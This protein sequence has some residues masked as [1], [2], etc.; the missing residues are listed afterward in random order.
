MSRVGEDEE[1]HAEKEKLHDAQANENQKSESVDVKQNNAGGQANAGM[2]LEELRARPLDELR[3]RFA[4]MG[5]M[6]QHGLATE[7]R[8]AIR[9][10]KYFQANTLSIYNTS[11]FP[12]S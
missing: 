1:E 4:N 6:I 9:L 10:L 7:E 5:Q 2:S 11:M 12:N 8:M 3:M